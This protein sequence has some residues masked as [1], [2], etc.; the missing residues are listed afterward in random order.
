MTDLETGFAVMMTTTARSAMD[1]PIDGLRSSR[2][3][4]AG[5]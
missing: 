2:G 5:G 4:R 1:A 3:Y